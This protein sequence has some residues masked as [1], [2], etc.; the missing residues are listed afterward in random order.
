MNLTISGGTTPSIRVAAGVNVTVIS[1]AVNVTV[2]VKDTATPPVAIESARVLMLAAAGGPMPFDVTL[3]AGAIT[4][5]GSTE[6]VAHTAH[7]MATNDKV[8]IKGAN[9]LEY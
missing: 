6:T 9:E 5:S 7:N 3:G 8:Q 4:R 2:T 1:G